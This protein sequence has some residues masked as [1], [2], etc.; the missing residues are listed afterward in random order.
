MSSGSSRFE[1]AVEPTRSQNMTVSWRRSASSRGTGAAEIG[2]IATALSPGWAIARSILRRCPS[3]TPRSL[4]SWSV[5]SRR[6]ERSIPFSAKSWAYSD[7][8]SDANHSAMLSTA[9]LL[10]AAV[11]CNGRKNICSA[12]LDNQRG[13][14]LQPEVVD[15]IRCAVR[16]TYDLFRFLTAPEPDCEI[17][18]CPWIRVQTCVSDLPAEAEARDVCYLTGTVL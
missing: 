12:L 17:V 16:L 9:Y 8:P 15:S 13:G 6:T 14:R 7:K 3:K 18:A 2:N 4:R 10:K 1:R 11:S 5:R